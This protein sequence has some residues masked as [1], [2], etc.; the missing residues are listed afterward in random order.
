[1]S[2]LPNKAVLRHVVDV[3]CH[4]TDA[5]SIS[6]DSMDRLDIIICAMSTMKQDQQKVRE[7][8]AFYP[9]KVIPCFGYHPWFSYLISIGSTTKEEHYKKLLLESSK[10]STT[11]IEAFTKL[12][13]M[14]PDPMPLSE[15]LADLRKSFSLFPEKSM[16][17]EVG[18]DRIF[19]IPYD[20]F[21]NPRQLT[22]FTIPIDHQTAILEA[23]LDL[24]VELGRNVSIHSVKSQLAT[25]E[26]LTRMQKKH[27][28]KWQQINV[29]MHSCGLS[30]ETW[31]QLEKKHSN[32]F[33]SLSTVINSRHANH[34][35]LIACCSPERILVESDYNDVEM[36][37]GKTWEILCT[38]AD[39]KGWPIE[40]DW[41][42]VGTAAMG[43]VHRLEKNWQRFSGE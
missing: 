30:P 31:R 13:P 39:I 5:P 14:L 38:I 26:L 32:V 41:E 3:H 33:L 24:A 2:N 6:S 4:P 37:T 7:L 11:D 25:I 40:E 8:A 9:E 18:L 27:G 29:D 20:Y 16:L 1:M 17:G 43:A 23:Q 22:P 36:V 19:R 28:T 35:A 10:S 12:L 34:R 21:A 15:M 42:E